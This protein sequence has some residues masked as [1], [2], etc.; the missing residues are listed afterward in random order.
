[1]IIKN[2]ELVSDKVYWHQFDEF[3]FNNI[4]IDPQNI[5]EIGIAKGNSIRLLRDKYPLASI[6]GFD[7]IEQQSSWP[8][9][10]NIFYYKVDQG[11]MLSFRELMYRINRR[12]DLIIED[13]SHD[14]LHQKISLIECLNFISEGGIYVLEDLHT[15]KIKHRLYIERGLKDFPVKPPW[16][17]FSNKPKNFYN[18]FGPL[19]CLLLIDFFIRKNLIA[20]N[21]ESVDFDKSLFSLSEIELLLKKV[22]GIDFFK[23]LRLPYYCYNCKKSDF[24]FSTLKCN[25]GADLYSDTDSM[26]SII[27]F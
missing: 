12:F 17:N 10:D 19:H 14:P 11:D 22:K 15:A 27:R 13:G 9:D 3:Y 5:L 1:M 23:R 7:I 20:I 24:N 26:T 16:F 21:S 6:F 8:V 25:C 2:L 18:Y 4:Q